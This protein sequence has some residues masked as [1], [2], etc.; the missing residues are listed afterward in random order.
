M[1]VV[2]DEPHCFFLFAID[3]RGISVRYWW[4]REKELFM[5]TFICPNRGWGIGY[6]PK[7][8]AIL[9]SSMDRVDRI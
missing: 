6:Q 1:T 5:Y 8:D 3:R 4:V 2:I 7:L 9:S